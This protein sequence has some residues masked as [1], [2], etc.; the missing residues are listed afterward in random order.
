MLMEGSVGGEDLPPPPPLSEPEEPSD[1]KPEKEADSEMDDSISSGYEGGFTAGGVTVTVN[2]MAE[3]EETP[4]PPPPPPLISHES[5]Q[6]PSEP[7]QVAPPSPIIATAVGASSA[8]SQSSSSGSGSQD[9]GSGSVES[10][11]TVE[12]VPP[13]DIPGPTAQQASDSS[14][15]P[16]NQNLEQHEQITPV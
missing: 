9:T 14:S 12:C 3:V 11:V 16:E 4:E 5:P 10:V 6:A 2:P 13:P 1:V 8:G 7:P 15:S